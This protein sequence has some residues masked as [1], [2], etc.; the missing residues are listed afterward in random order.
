MPKMSAFCA[1]FFSLSPF[2]RLLCFLSEH[3]NRQQKR[4]ASPCP[5][6]KTAKVSIFGVVRPGPFLTAFLINARFALVI[7]RLYL[8]WCFVFFAWFCFAL[9]CFSF[10]RSVSFSEFPGRNHSRQMYYNNSRIYIISMLCV[11]PT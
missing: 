5:I 9:L 8:K 7:C 1:N 11:W 6:E 10:S 3:Q 2:I 4:H